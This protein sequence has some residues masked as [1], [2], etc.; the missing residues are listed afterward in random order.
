MRRALFACTLFAAVLLSGCRSAPARIEAH[1]PRAD[2]ERTVAQPSDAGTWPLTGKP[3]LDA[4]AVAEPAIAV[5][6]ADRGGAALPGLDS[7]D[8]VFELATA[9]PRILALF[10]SALPAAAG[11]L[12]RGVP[13]DRA[14]TASYHAALLGG[15][16]GTADVAR[17]TV[18]TTTELGGP[19]MLAF[20]AQQI[21]PL[22]GSKVGSLVLRPG[23][24]D[25][26]WRYDPGADAYLRFV[27]GAQQRGTGATP[28]QA[29]N[30][31]VVWSR[32]VDAGTT[33]D[34][35]GRA[36]LF[37]QGRKFSGSWET[38]GGPLRFRD[39]NGQLLP[40]FAGDTWVEVL[41]TAATIT[42]R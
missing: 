29:T 36:S 17:A 40:L 19:P 24:W 6:V 18:S 13:D 2:V 34:G 10:H 35:S 20:A 8:L 26:E 25:V 5:A 16:A 37:M 31:A 39:E 11:P 33:L 32:T 22:A 4:S 28:L 23:D 41:P 7:A 15:A 21:A 9:P 30:V 1:W 14:L 38:S 12:R 3:A 27:G 42:V